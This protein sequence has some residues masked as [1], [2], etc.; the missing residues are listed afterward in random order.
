MNPKVAEKLAVFRKAEVD[1][2]AEIEE[3]QGTCDH[4]QVLH[5][6]YRKLDY[7]GSL[8]PLRMC[9]VCRLEEEASIWS[10]RDSWHPRHRGPAVLGNAPH[11]LVVQADRESIYK[12][13]LPGP[14]HIVEQK[15][16]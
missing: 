12:L 9:A 15:E 11:R 3:A 13:R 10:G 2:Q 16:D 7:F 8:E 1:L 14:R 4:P 6:D 5:A